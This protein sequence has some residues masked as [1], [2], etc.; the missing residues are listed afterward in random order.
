MASPPIVMKGV[1]KWSLNPDDNATADD[2]INWQEGQ[3]PSS[4]N[5]SAR[6]MMMRIREQHDLNQSQFKSILDT[7]GGRFGTQIKAITADT[8]TIEAAPYP[9]NHTIITFKLA[10]GT[11]TADEH[12]QVKSGKLHLYAHLVADKIEQ[13]DIYKTFSYNSIIAI[14]IIIDVGSYTE[15]V[16]MKFRLNFFG[17]EKTND[18]I[19]FHELQYFV[20]RHILITGS[21]SELHNTNAIP[22]KRTY[23]GNKTMT[24]D[25]AESFNIDTTKTSNLEWYYISPTQCICT[26]NLDYQARA[27]RE[28]AYAKFLVE[29]DIPKQ[30]IIQLKTNPRGN[31]NI[32]FGVDDRADLGKRWLAYASRPLVGAIN[33]VD[34][35]DAHILG[36]VT[37]MI[38]GTPTQLKEYPMILEPTATNSYPIIV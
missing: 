13:N 22:M 4:V 14:K 2:R 38:I 25:S 11:L 5:N 16:H 36:D 23:I 18:F 21:N 1:S 32:S 10:G 12:N 20:N 15:N 37:F 17:I 29:R 9:A 3:M 8:Y 19:S 7:V 26:Q 28:Q 24:P 30:N 33:S 27:S 31:I 6:A 35:I 34:T